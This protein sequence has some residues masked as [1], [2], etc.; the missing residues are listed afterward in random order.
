YV[1]A[2]GAAGESTILQA[3]NAKIAHDLP[4]A[5]EHFR[6]LAGP[7]RPLAWATWRDYP[8]R[9]LATLARG[10][11]LIVASRQSRTEG[12]AYA[13]NPA[14]LV[15][16]A[17]APVLLAADGEAEFRGDHVIVAWKDTRESRRA[18]TD[19]LPFLRRAK[20]VN[21]IV[22]SDDSP[23]DKPDDISRRLA[24]HGVDASVD[25][26]PRGGRPVSAVLQAAAERCSADLIVAGAYGRTRVSEWALGGV[27]KD[28]IATSPAFLLLSH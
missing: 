27:T 12:N 14:D 7:G 28:L 8:F 25:V 21:V 2:Y 17:G 1:P 20:S 19:G 16:R 24:G 4:A 13:A 11:D 15:L 3:I 23:D 26:I 9:A 6:A 10:A 22:V 18:L 5:E